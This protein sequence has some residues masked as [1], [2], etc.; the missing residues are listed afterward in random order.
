LPEAAILVAQ[1]KTKIARFARD[2]KGLGDNGIETLLRK[3]F[4]GNS[5]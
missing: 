4:Y 5:G 2:G 1:A 3:D